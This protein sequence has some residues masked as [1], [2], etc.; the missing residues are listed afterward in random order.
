MC[1]RGARLLTG[2]GSLLGEARLVAH[3]L[4]IEADD[5]LVLVDTGFGTGDVSDPGRL[6]RPFGAVV[7]PKLDV[8]ETA[9]RQVKALGFDP[10]DVRHILITHLDLDHAGGLGDFPDADVHVFAPELAAATSPTRREAA[11][12]IK[13]QWAHGPKWVEHQVDGDS[14]L[15]FDSVRVL[16]GVDGD[17]AMVPLT[18][19]TRGHTGI[20]LRDGDGWLLHCGDAFFHH[21]EIQTPPAAPVGVRLYERLMCVNDK[22]RERNQERLRELARERRGEVRLI[23]SHDPELLDGA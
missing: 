16:P 7:R 11:R 10:A 19:H 6:G 23:C 9:V 2:A 12:Y 21:G 13:A 22:R 1:P 8:T 14:W 17:V 15:G 18:G 5:G 20:V 3:C 4:L